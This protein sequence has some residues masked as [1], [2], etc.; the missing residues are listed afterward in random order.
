M[1]GGGVRGVG[2]WGETRKEDAGM[3]EWIPN[4]AALQ[5][6]IDACELKW[7]GS[8][9]GTTP[10]YTYVVEC[11]GQ[12]KFGHTTDIARRISAFQVANV[13][14]VNLVCWW[15]SFSPESLEEELFLHFQ[16]RNIRG[17]WH[18]LTLKELA[19]IKVWAS[20]QSIP[21]YLKEDREERISRLSPLSIYRRYQKENPV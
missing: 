10:G 15:I 1:G 21:T 2:G 17:E 19:V 9:E 5:R 8:T 7:P 20:Q 4:R 16:H 6:W 11:G 3:S 18:A 14:S 12:Y 13:Q